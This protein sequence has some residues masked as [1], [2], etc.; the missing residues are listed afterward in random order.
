MD[1][2]LELQAGGEPGLVIR[3]GGL[4]QVSFNV[5]GVSKRDARNNNAY[6]T[7]SFT[8]IEEFQLQTG[9]FNAEY[10]NLRSGLVNVVT[11]DP[12][13]TKFHADAF[14]R[15]RSSPNYSFGDGPKGADAYYWRPFTDPEVALTGTDNGKWDRYTQRQ[16]FAFAGGWNG[17]AEG[18]LGD[19][20]P[21]NDLTA[22][23][24]QE[25]FAYHHRKETE[26]QD[27]EHTLDFTLSGP[28]HQIRD[29]VGC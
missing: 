6:T 29:W 20:D 8:A 11:K 15:Y 22:A 5:D 26:V 16:Y 9:G 21:S 28:W 13:K 17:L 7:V 14:V 3:G 1:Q 25:L 2:A 23:Q 10:G 24:Y 12:S 19:D 27:N 4:D 18:A